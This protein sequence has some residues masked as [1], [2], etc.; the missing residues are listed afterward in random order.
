MAG[1]T[2]SARNIRTRTLAR[3]PNFGGDGLKAGDFS[4]PAV[5]VLGGFDTVRVSF[6]SLLESGASISLFAI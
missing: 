6:H 4:S 3:R 5:R 1:V 2:V